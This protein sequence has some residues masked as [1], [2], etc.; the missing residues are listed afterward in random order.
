MTHSLQD[1]IDSFERVTQTRVLVLASHWRGDRAVDLDDDALHLV[2]D[3]LATHPSPQVPLCV[4]CVGRGGRLEFADGIRRRLPQGS[5]VCVPDVTRGA[6]T[7]IALAAAR[8]EL[9]PGAG[10]GAYDSGTLGRFPGVWSLQTLDHVDR[11]LMAQLDAESSSRIVLR[12]ALDASRRAQARAMA[13]L[14]VDQPALDALGVNALGDELALGERSLQSLGMDATQTSS[15]SAAFFEVWT[16]IA[17]AL[18]LHAAV[19]SRAQADDLMGEIEFDLTSTYPGALIGMS[20][21]MWTLQLDA[22]LPDPDS[23]M[24]KGHWDDGAPRQDDEF[25]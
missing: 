12:L 17:E 18:E 25:L 19:E 2:D 20:H 4:W 10:L 22:G 8:L 16:A 15:W 1:A 14:M 23:G 11:A 9:G 6:M 3:L 7:L 13:R 21:K 24:L 5:V